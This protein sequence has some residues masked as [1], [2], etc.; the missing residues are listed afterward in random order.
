M[1]QE[2]DGQQYLYAGVLRTVGTDS[3]V[4]MSTLNFLHKYILTHNNR[5]LS[6]FRSQSNKDLRPCSREFCWIMY[7]LTFLSKKVIYISP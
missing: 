7:D 4:E 2:E 3:F 1:N 6:W 5:L